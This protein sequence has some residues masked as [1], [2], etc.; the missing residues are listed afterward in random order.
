MK[1]IPEEMSYQLAVRIMK[2]ILAGIIVTLAS[3]Q[4][5]P[6]KGKTT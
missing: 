5:Q 3:N 2:I 4:Y 1:V 6:I